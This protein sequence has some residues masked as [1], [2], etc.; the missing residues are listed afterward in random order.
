[1]PELWRSHDKTE[2]EAVF[3]K[4]IRD[5]VIQLVDPLYSEAKRDPAG[6]RLRLRKEAGRR[7]IMGISIPEK[8]GGQGGSVMMQGIAKEELGRSRVVPQIVPAPLLTIYEKFAE[9][10]N[11]ALV[12]EWM[13]KFLN[14]DAEGGIGS[15]EP[16][17]GSDISGFVTTATKKGKSYILSGEKGPVS[18]V[19]SSDAYFVLARTGSEGSGAKG[20][21]MFFVESDLPGIK[22]SSFKA[23]EETWELGAVKFDNVEIPEENLI[24]KEGRGFYQMMGS[25]DIER[26]LLPMGYVGAATESL[27]E[28][29]SYTKSRVVWGR[30]IASFEGIMFPL[31]EAVARM[32]AVRS[33]MYDIMRTAESE[34]NVTKYASMARW[35]VTRTALDALDTCIQVNGAQGYTDLV[36]HERR[37]RWVRS[38]LIGHGTQEIQK[39]V[40]GR[41]IFGKEIYD[42]ALGR[43]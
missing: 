9:Y 31:V 34:K 14:G 27:E 12:K 7:G 13:P 40:I 6:V 2:E 39:L 41:E 35:L 30:P 5:F 8:Y 20:V 38:G 18:G 26:I 16:G 21:S 43:R 1:M 10:G 29:I 23:M 25:L 36:P 37:Y 28:S 19:S 24:G 17:S 33:Y 3:R 22:K 42:L 32:E 4:T 15:T 11:E